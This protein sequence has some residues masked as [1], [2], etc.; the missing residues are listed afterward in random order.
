MID[1]IQTIDERP[2]S[3][4]Q[5]RI[6]MLC[7]LVMFFDGYDLQVMGIATPLM[8]EAFGIPPSAFGYALS[9]SLLGLAPGAALGGPWG[10]RSGRKTVLATGLI[11]AGLFTLA[12]IFVTN[13]AYLL[14]ARFVTGF[15]L[16]VM[17]PN[18]VTLTSE[19]M[20]QRRRAWLTT[21]MYCGVGIGAFA[22]GWCA[23]FLLAQGG[24]RTLFVV[25][26][27]GSLITAGLILA[28]APESIK[29]LL[30]RKPTSPAIPSI[31]RRLGI[32]TAAQAVGIAP[33]ASHRL[34]PTE[35]F[36]RHYIGR[37]LVLWALYSFNI[38]TVHFLTSW[39]PSILI[40]A[41][42]PSDDA[43]QGAVLLQLGGTVGGIVIATQMGR[44][45]P[46][47]VLAAG[48][49]LGAICLTVMFLSSSSQSVWSLALLFGG[50]GIVG[51]Q[52]MLTA[53]IAEVYPLTIRSTGVG[54]A[55]TVGRMG[56]ITAPIAGAMMIDTLS[57]SNILG[58]LVLPALVCIL[59]ALSI[60]RQWI[61]A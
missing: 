23:P 24:W 31:L 49:A 37:T 25:G 29:F 26:G 30:A 36:Q 2:I 8:A 21:V 9:A 20:P 13:T 58:I 28:L 10:D 48:Y 7:T 55:V 59:L 39:L 14:V 50:V 27:I 57:A 60:R 53:L 51:G 18:T 15:G 16:G 40:R 19:F 32:E 42:W 35:L 45:R 38:F 11:V 17:L 56:A 46:N 47:Q 22:A 54:A 12:T 33:S 3:A 4:L 41:G 44:A 1:I 5:W 52:L 43:L 34:K 61:E 6:L